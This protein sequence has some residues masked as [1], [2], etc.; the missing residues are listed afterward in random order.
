MN[1]LHTSIQA[2]LGHYNELLRQVKELRIRVNGAGGSTD[3]ANDLATAL[4][5]Q[6]TQAVS[7]ALAGEPEPAKDCP[8][9]VFPFG[10][11]TVP[12]ES[13]APPVPVNPVPEPVAAAETQEPSVT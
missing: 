12:V 13:F 4:V 8:A 7:Q 3:D 2:L 9:P 11:P 5:S 6:H 10:V 1:N